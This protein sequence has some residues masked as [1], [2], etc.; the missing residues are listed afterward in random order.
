M[1]MS[2]LVIFT[3]TFSFQFLTKSWVRLAVI[4]VAMSLVST[5]YIIVFVPESPQFLYG[6]DR[7]QESRASLSTVARANFVEY[8]GNKKY[9]DL[10]FIGEVKLTGEQLMQIQE[11]E[12]SNSHNQ[13]SVV[14]KEAA[15]ILDQ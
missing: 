12:S 14:T 7:F 6:A 2:C 8:V 9:E 3:F 13:V 5:I 10:R 4:F 15:S 1:I 11:F